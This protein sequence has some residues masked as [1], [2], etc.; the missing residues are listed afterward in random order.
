MKEVSE[1]YHQV[2]L[3]LESD[4]P[5]PESFPLMLE[6]YNISSPE[7]DAINQDMQN[8]LSL[9]ASLEKHP[10]K[11]PSEHIAMIRV[12]ESNDTLNETLHELA[13]YSRLQ[14]LIMRRIKDV[15]LYPLIVFSFILVVFGVIAEFCVLP[16][17]QVYYDLLDGEPLPG[18]TEEVINISVWVTDH[19][20][21]YRLLSFL[22]ISFLFGLYQGFIK[23][24]FLKVTWFYFISLCSSLPETLDSSKLCSYMS[25][26]L[27]HS[28]DFP[29]T[30]HA[31]ANLVNSPWLKQEMKDAAVRMSNGESCNDVLSSMNI[32]NP[33]IIQSL[34]NSRTNNIPKE[35][36]RLAEHFHERVYR[37]SETLVMYWQIILLSLL[38]VLTIGVVFALIQPFVSIGSGM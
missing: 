31:S 33:L 8:G 18:I 19:Y 11:F 3:L 28:S 14:F 10:T 22:L 21:V 38:G 17:K 5:L 36:D 13:Q 4:L 23:I 2:S 7:L 37:L 25:L 16:F 29:S 30:C 35:L 15:M 1:F 34:V 20:I 27:Q 9:S 6:T 24:P 26:Q 12:A 32:M